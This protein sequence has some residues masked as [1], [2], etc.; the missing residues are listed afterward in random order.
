MTGRSK[1]ESKTYRMDCHAVLQLLA[2]TI[3]L[4]S[5]LSAKA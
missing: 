5:S 1:R 3:F 4:D 2:I